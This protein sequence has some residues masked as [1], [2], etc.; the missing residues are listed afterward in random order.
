MRPTAN[1]REY[2]PPPP[3][4]GY[5]QCTWVQSVGQ[6][7]KEFLQRVLPDG[8]ADILWID[9]SEPVIVGPATQAVVVPLKAGQQ[10]TAAR[11]RPGA[12]NA[13]LQIAAWELRDRQLPL[14]DV[15]G[16]SRRL[17]QTIANAR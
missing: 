11:I 17:V 12:V 15:L 10:I 4:S 8:C 13:L 7:D 16:P 5:L 3:L 1:Y 2:A 14:R 9:D 6:G